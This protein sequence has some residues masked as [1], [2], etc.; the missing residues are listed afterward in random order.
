M[1][2]PL[3][4]FK[5]GLST[6]VAAVSLSGCAANIENIPA[7][8]RDAPKEVEHDGDH[9]VVYNP[10]GFTVLRLGEDPV[11]FVYNAEFNDCFLFEGRVADYR[12]R[13]DDYGCDLNA[14][15]F[16]NKSLK[17]S[18]FSDKTKEDLGALL[19]RRR[20]ELGAAGIYETWKGRWR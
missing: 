3:K 12:L 14:D 6:L 10:T 13:V 16:E 8:S 9:T 19:L 17:A 11:A 15:S 7:F 18:S 1:K 2:N 4:N 5:F 20:I